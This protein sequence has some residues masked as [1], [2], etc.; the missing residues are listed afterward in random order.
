[1]PLLR[2]GPAAEAR[3]PA[4]RIM[5]LERTVFM[6][7]ICCDRWRMDPERVVEDGDVWS[8]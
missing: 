3:W 2:A 4:G 1:M 6:S 5:E 8:Q 7:A